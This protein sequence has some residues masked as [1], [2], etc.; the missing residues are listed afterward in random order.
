VGTLL[1]ISGSVSSL[2]LDSQ[3]GVTLAVDHLDGVFD[4]VPGLLLGHAIELVHTDDGCSYQ[5]AQ[6]SASE[7]ASDESIVGVIGTS[8]S[9]ASLG[10]A[11]AILSDAGVVLISPSN[12]NPL[13]TAE[14]HHQPF[15]LRTSQNDT[16][17]AIVAADFAWNELEVATAATIHDETPY[18][19]GLRE[20]FVE[21]FRALGGRIA[22]QRNIQGSNKRFTSMLKEIAADTSDLVYMPLFSPAAESIVNQ[23]SGIEALDGTVLLG[24]DAVMEHGFVDAVDAAAARFYATSPDYSPIEASSIRA[25]CCPPTETSTGRRQRSS[26][27]TRSTRRT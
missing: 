10:V 15:Y 23:A 25:T 14:S 4:A 17:Q 1:A 9:N 19:D 3:R 11:D 27:P 2:G 20:T 16:L 7:L 12:T 8:C 24:T 6:V 26:T 13:L 22:S 5:Q 18:S 21:A